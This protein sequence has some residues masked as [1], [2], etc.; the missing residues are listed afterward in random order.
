MMWM[1]EIKEIKLE[2]KMMRLIKN[3]AFR[4]T[5]QMLAITSISLL[6]CY[7]GNV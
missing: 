5:L 3:E 7:L 6:I 1:I 4:F 2:K